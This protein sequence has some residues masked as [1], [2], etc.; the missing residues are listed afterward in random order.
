MK[1]KISWQ[2]QFGGWRPFQTKHNEA[3]SYRVA[4]RRAKATGKRH[5][6]TTED[7]T[8]LDLIEP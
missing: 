3:D 4:K 8:L 2:D 7:G 5:R 1:I 6:L